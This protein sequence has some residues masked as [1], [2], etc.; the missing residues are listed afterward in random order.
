MQKIVASEFNE[1]PIRRTHG[2]LLP[3]N[4]VK[5]LW[6]NIVKRFRLILRRKIQSEL[7]NKPHTWR[8][9]KPRRHYRWVGVKHAKNCSL[10]I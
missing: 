4:I 10:R 8:M 2:S 5:R 3:G 7:T 9:T 1:H 6:R